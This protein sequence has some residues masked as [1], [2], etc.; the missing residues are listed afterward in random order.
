MYQETLPYS[1]PSAPNRDK[2]RRVPMTYEE[3]VAWDTPL[4]PEQVA[5]LVGILGTD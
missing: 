1:L 2:E 3:Y 4:T 5:A